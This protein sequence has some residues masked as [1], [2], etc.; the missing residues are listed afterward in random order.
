MKK[1]YISPSTL[2]VRVETLNMIAQSTLEIKGTGNDESLLL[3]RGHNSNL[4]DD[5]DED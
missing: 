2:T 3:G 5:E 1:T 4:W